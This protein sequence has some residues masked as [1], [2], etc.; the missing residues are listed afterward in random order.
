MENNNSTDK[1]TVEF[2]LGSTLIQEKLYRADK[3][4]VPKKLVHDESSSL[5]PNHQ[6]KD[7]IGLL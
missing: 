1:G 7:Q 4:L 5:L 6:I 2:L 3:C